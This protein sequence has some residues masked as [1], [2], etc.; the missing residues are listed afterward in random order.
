LDREF[1]K[2][3]IKAHWTLTNDFLKPESEIDELAKPF[4]G[5]DDPVFGKRTTLSLIDLFDN[6]KLSTYTLRSNVDIDIIVGVGASLFHD[7]GALVYIDIPKNEI[8]FRGRANSAFNLGKREIIDYKQFY[9]RLYFFDWILLNKQKQKLLPAIDYFI[10]GQRENEIS[11]IKGDNL[12][13]ALA[14]MSHHAFRVR[15]WFE[16][17]VWGG[18]W[19]KNKIKN[20]NQNVPN[21]A[22]SFELIVPENGIILQSSNYLLELSF[23]C[24]MFLKG[25]EI[26][27]KH[28]KE[29]GYEFPIRFDFL[30]TFNGG[31]LSVQCHPRLEYMKEHFGEQ[32][33]QEESYYILDAGEKAVCYIGFQE[34]IDPKAFEEDLDYS[35]NNNQAIDITKHV[36]KLKSKKH[37]LFL[38]PPGTIHGSGIDNLVLEISTTPYI[39][40]FKM[41]DWVRPDLDG[42]PRPLNI[43]RGMDNLYFDRKG[44]KVID[45]HISRPEL[46]SKGNDWELYQLPT[47]Q[48]H[49]YEVI[50]YHFE[51]EITVDTRDTV[52]VLSLVEG[53]S[54]DIEVQRLKKEYHYA[55]TVVV[56]AAAKKY[57]IK[58]NSEQK[59]I[60]VVA[61]MKHE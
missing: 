18:N 8:Q 13:S 55:E 17:G 24:L 52:H 60:V 2:K 39:F 54:I 41:Y 33:T 23:D 3:G 26:L 37:D 51:T 32:I 1:K 15:P 19:I 61:Y 29:Y 4:L 22:W 14:E 16:P 57:R 42:K 31:N 47:H 46:I 34:S 36:Q 28:F 21:Y 6:E 7:K 38:I 45:K 12:R 25:K 56:P 27:G 5:G 53:D 20:L 11:W 48:N 35:F 59:A 49:S 43:Q 9:K 50:R 10:D 40:T 58:N 44:Q 30:D